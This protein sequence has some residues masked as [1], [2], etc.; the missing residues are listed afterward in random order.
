M[1]KY[2]EKL[3]VMLKS[4]KWQE[5][6]VKKIGNEVKGLI[7]G[8]IGFKQAK[9]DQFRTYKFK[10]EISYRLLMNNGLM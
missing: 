3:K 4:F 10:F 7:Q 9:K 6:R 8:N 1:K 5:N 2:D